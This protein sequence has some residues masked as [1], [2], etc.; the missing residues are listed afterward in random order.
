MS[1]QQR[2]SCRQRR[3]SSQISE[4]GLP[5]F[6]NDGCNSRIQPSA[7]HTSQIGCVFISHQGSWYRDVEPHASKRLLQRPSQTFVLQPSASSSACQQLCEMAWILVNLAHVCLCVCTPFLPFTSGAIWLLCDMDSI[8]HSVAQDLPPPHLT[9][10]LFG[11]LN[12]V[13]GWSESFDP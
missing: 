7:A 6:T 1:P 13:W 9:H 2:G 12:G 3:L 10:Q 5:G 11:S 8:F 4:R